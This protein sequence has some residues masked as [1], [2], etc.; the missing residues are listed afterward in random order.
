[1]IR[2]ENGPSTSLLKLF[3]QITVELH[4]IVL[5][6]DDGYF[7]AVRWKVAQDAL[8]HSL[9]PTLDDAVRDDNTLNERL[10]SLG[11]IEIAKFKEHVATGQVDWEKTIL[12]GTHPLALRDAAV[13]WV[14]LD[15]E[16]IV[17]FQ[18]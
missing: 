18:R 13:L 4:R 14:T 17:K 15:A 2:L 10:E 7:F 5:G 8:G 12:A 16:T 6:H 11:D 9:E 1:M 3:L